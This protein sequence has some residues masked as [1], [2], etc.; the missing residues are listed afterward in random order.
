[1]MLLS[2]VFLILFSCNKQ[3]E[4]V[5]EDIVAVA[6]GISQM[7]MPPPVVVKDEEI[8]QENRLEIASISAPQPEAPNYKSTIREKKIIK[9]GKMIVSAKDIHA[10]KKSID[11]LIKQLNAYYEGEDLQNNDHSVAYHL[12]IR[13][14]CAN[15]EKLIS[16]LEN[17]K[18]E[19][20]SKNIA[21]RDVTEEYIDTE[22]RL[23]NKR[24]YLKRYKEL[25]SK[26]ATVKDLLAIEENIRNLQ[27]EIEA[28]K[29]D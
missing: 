7:K 29:G 14:P 10:N 21:T 5:S 28:K 11:N 19:I 1:V 25:L 20:R 16:G 23:A 13:V 2:C 6:D 8:T 15:F 24:D 18:D 12:K 27:E 9:D 4:A 17:G 3:Q 22:T 26:A